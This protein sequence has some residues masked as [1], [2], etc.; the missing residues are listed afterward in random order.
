MRCKKLRYLKIPPRHQ[1]VCALIF[2]DFLICFLT[3][4]A[5]FIGGEVRNELNAV[6]NDDARAVN[7]IALLK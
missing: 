6:V 3:I 5:S 4:H 1:R 2:I 7:F